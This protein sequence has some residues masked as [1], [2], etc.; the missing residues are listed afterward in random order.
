[1]IVNKKGCPLCGGS[2]RFI[3]MVAQGR[4][5]E[6]ACANC[7]VFHISIKA[8]QM[9]FS[10]FGASGALYSMLAK[11]SRPEDLLVISA[12]SNSLSYQ[13]VSIEQLNGEKIDRW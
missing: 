4:Q 11:R 8:V 1:M 13:Y 10:N 5:I 7:T 9:L 6:I 12:T 3:G 2:C